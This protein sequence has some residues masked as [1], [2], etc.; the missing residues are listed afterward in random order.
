MW[1]HWPRRVLTW[2]DEFFSVADSVKQRGPFRRSEEGFLLLYGNGR[3]RPTRPSSKDQEEPDERKELGR[4]SAR[5]R[6]AAGLLRLCRFSN[7]P[8]PAAAR[9]TRPQPLPCRWSRWC[10]WP[11]RT[12]PVPRMGGRARRLG[13]RGHPAAGERL[14]AAPAV[15]GLVRKAGCCSRSIPAPS[16]PRSTR[17]APPQRTRPRVTSPGRRPLALTARDLARV[18]PLAAKNAVSK[19]DTRRRHR[20][21]N[22][23][24]GPGSRRPGPAW[25]WPW[26]IS[27]RR[28]SISVS[29]ASPRRWTASPASPRPGLGNLVGPSMQEELTSVSRGRSDQGLHQRQRTG[30]SPLPDLW[31]RPGPCHGADPAPG[32]RQCLCPRGP[33]CHG[34][35]ARGRPGTTGTLKLGA[36]FPNPDRMLRPGLCGASGPR[37]RSARALLHIPQRAVTRS[38]AAPWWPWSAPTTPSRCDRSPRSTSGSAVTG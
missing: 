26:P 8:S 5:R 6:Q 10:G 18:R 14:P 25:P 21:G 19:K 22:A 13:Q 33:F 15:P 37:S 38:R 36:L 28:N 30:I 23:A 1:P 35:P 16:R 9:S 20:P 24:T 17:P 29:P 31:R 7:C 4:R 3:P 11:S 34:R 27:T 12:C 32:R 2:I